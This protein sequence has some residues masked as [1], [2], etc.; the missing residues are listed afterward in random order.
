MQPVTPEPFIELLNRASVHADQLYMLIDTGTQP[1][2]HDRW[3]V[4]LERCTDPWQYLYYH[5]EF[6]H[7]CPVSPL[8]LQVQDGHIGNDMLQQLEG[9]RWG[10][11]FTSPFDLNTLLAHW[12]SWLTVYLPS[13]QE[14]LF[15]LYSPRILSLFLQS[16]YI[17]EEDR[18]R[19]THPLRDIYLP[20]GEHRYH[21]LYHNPAVASPMLPASGWFHVEDELYAEINA[22]YREEWLADLAVELFQLSPL[23]C[24]TLEHADVLRGLSDG[25][26]RAATYRHSSDKLRKAF[27]FAQFLYGSRFWQLPQFEH[28]VHYGSLRDALYELERR[29]DWQ[30]QVRE[31]FHDAQWLEKL[32]QEENA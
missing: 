12:Q 23:T 28:E 17:D 4:P 31:A 18:Y 32:Q 11:L 24:M 21:A 6:A 30:Q 9:D 7:L 15:R 25:L 8:L 16:D 19:L 14:H 2:F 3:S 22:L 26:A 13:G 1:G 5:T 29:P 20:A 10:C 27:A